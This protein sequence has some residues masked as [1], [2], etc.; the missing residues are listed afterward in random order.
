MNAE[1]RPS[2][3][4]SNKVPAGGPSLKR[5]RRPWPLDMRSRA[6]LGDE[7]GTGDDR[8]TRERRRVLAARE[9]AHSY[10]QRRHREL[11]DAYLDEV[12][13]G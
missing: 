6:E 3:R 4:P 10:R 9:A 8:P 12:R 7:P 11:A 2:G 13:G 5:T 1:G